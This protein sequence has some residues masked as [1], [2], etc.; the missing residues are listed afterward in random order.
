M[1]RR[2]MRKTIILAMMA[3]LATGAVHGEVVATARSPEGKFPEFRVVLDAVGA[4][5]AVA[6]FMGLADGSQKWV[7]P[8]SGQV[9]GGAGD[10]YYDGMVFDFADGDAV[11]GGMR[12]IPDGEGGAKYEGGPGYAVLGK[13][14]EAWTVAEE[15]TLVLVENDGPHSG[16]GEVAL[17]L[18]NGVTTQW[19]VLGRVRAEDRSGLQTLGTLVRGGNMVTVEWTVDDSGATAAEQS[20]LEV[21]RAKLPQPFGIEASIG[22]N[23]T[24]VSFD[25]PGRS[26]LL[27]F[28]SEDLLNGFGY[29]GE[30]WREVEEEETVG[31]TWQS[32]GLSGRQGFISLTGLTQPSWSGHRFSGKCWMGMEY[33]DHRE[34]IWWD[35]GAG[36]GLVAVVEGGEVMGTTTFSQASSWRVTGN[37][38]MA[39]YGRGFTGHYHYLGVAEEGAMGGRFMY[40]QTVLLDEV[41]RAWGMYEMEEGWA[42]EP[43]VV[44]SQSVAAK[45]HAVQ[46]ED[47][48]TSVRQGGC[49]STIRRMRGG[50]RRAVGSRPTPAWALWGEEELETRVFGERNARAEEL[51]AFFDSFKHV[52]CLGSGRVPKEVGDGGLK[53]DGLV[54][55]T[56]ESESN[57][58]SIADDGVSWGEFEGATS[59]GEN[60][61]GGGG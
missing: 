14:G 39:Y 27:I 53:C 30:G 20:A 41:G 8:E 24:E 7:D 9:R 42:R 34:E 36:T 22:G 47:T 5:V 60:F 58:E 19:T 40:K 33:A 50:E 57:G 1:K 26:R 51:E 3:V 48:S 52:G 44:K 12:P 25:W 35:F 38:V 59:D 2:T 10:A 43:G 46:V 49:R 18:T 17:Y 45:H 11:R 31:L 54:E 29:L 32:L 13:T 28:S 56:S 6:N 23:G 37:N 4:P 21:A 15:G 55:T 61:V 16:G